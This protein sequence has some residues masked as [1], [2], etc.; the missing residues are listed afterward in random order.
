MNL[1]KEN[2]ISDTRFGTITYEPDD[3]LTFPQGLV[4]FP[5]EKQFLLVSTKQAS[6][7]RWLQSL[8]H[9][10]LAFLV[11]NPAEFVSGYS[12]VSEAK[13]GD[14]LLT[15]VNIPPGRPKEMTLNLAGPICIDLVS[16]TGKQIVLDNEAYTT[17]YR[18]FATASSESGDVAA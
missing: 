3:I 9:P 4:G 5:E 8:K 14:V 17:R 13:I 2:T 16:R 18:V 1:T 6:S 12:P 10:E 11:A 7:F 15:T